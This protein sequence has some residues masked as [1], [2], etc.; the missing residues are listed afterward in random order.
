MT[1]TGP[2][3]TRETGSVAGARPGSGRVPGAGKPGAIP[4]YNDVFDSFTAIH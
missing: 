3:T 1:V 4:L 2:R